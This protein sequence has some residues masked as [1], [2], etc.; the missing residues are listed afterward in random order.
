MTL[1]GDIQI[2]RCNS[3]VIWNNWVPSSVNILAGR[4]LHKRLPTKVNLEKRGIPLL[5]T[6]C[7]FC[8]R[9]DENEDHLFRDRVFTNRILK[10][11][12]VWWGLD[13]SFVHNNHSILDWA[14]IL[15]LPGEKRKAFNGVIFSFLW[16]IWSLRNRKIF[17]NVHR[18]KEELIFS[19]LQALS[20]FWIK[21]RSRLPSF[22]LKWAL[23]CTSPNE[24]HDKKANKRSSPSDQSQLKIN[25]NEMHQINSNEVLFMDGHENKND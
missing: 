11:I 17:D 7:S 10:E 1:L 8:N 24:S 19:H 3:Q 6:T 23:W 15:F 13:A 20:F 22:G 12:L 9:A 4:L 21:Q 2:S 25:T 18:G 14:D 5:T 16:L